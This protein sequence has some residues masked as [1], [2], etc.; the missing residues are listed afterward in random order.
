M[1]KIAIL[2][3][4]LKTDLEN[5]QI[6]LFEQSYNLSSVEIIHSAITIKATKLFVSNDLDENFQNELNI[7]VMN[8]GNMIF[9][10]KNTNKRSPDL[11]FFR[12]SIKYLMLKLNNL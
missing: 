5:L 9:V 8:L 2:L 3:T 10:E 1:K 4:A 12:V 7:L 6:E 11:G